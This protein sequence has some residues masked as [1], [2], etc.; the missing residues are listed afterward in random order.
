MSGID[1]KLVEFHNDRRYRGIVIDDDDEPG[2]VHVQW[3][4]PDRFIGLHRVVDLVMV[5]A[6]P[7]TSEEPSND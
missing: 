2:W 5:S 3:M 4:R 7:S 6:V 1:G